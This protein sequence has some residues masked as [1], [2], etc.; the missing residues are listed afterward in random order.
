MFFSDFQGDDGVPED[1][2]EAV[3]WYRMAAEQGYEA[4]KEWLERN[5]KENGEQGQGN[6]PLSPPPLRSKG[7]FKPL[8]PKANS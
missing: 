8:P 2:V 1:D 7:A 5:A 3:K 4:A 6:N